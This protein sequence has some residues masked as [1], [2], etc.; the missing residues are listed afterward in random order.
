MSVQATY[1]FDIDVK[2]ALYQNRNHCKRLIVPCYNR[3]QPAVVIISWKVLYFSYL[4]HCVLSI[5]I[6]HF[7]K[8][9]SY[10]CRS[11]TISL[12]DAF[13]NYLRESQKHKKLA[14]VI[15]VFFFF[16]KNK[17]S[18]LNSYLINVYYQIFRNISEINTPIYLQIEKTL[19][20]FHEFY[21]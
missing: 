6:N 16:Y 2:G 12:F 5:I 13:H 11:I 7:V 3:H 1:N 21:L 18:L 15:L 14:R 20:S 17:S 9:F 10:R 4:G 19:R 8:Y